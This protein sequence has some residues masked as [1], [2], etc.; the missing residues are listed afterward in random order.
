MTDDL[1]LQGN[2]I[3]LTIPF[4]KPEN[5]IKTYNFFELCTTYVAYVH[6]LP[7]IGGYPPKIEIYLAVE[8]GLW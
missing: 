1:S 3:G 4:L 7:K 8:L 6:V 5:K 2:R